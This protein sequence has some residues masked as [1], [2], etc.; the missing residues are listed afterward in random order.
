VRRLVGALSLI[1][2]LLT[3]RIEPLLAVFAGVLGVT[4]MLLLARLL[5]FRPLFLI[6]VASRHDSLRL[7]FGPSACRYCNC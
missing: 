3:L 6:L 2:P 4:L 5:R 7:K 1:D